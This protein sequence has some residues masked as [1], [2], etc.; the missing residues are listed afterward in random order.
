MSQLLMNLKKTT[1][2]TDKRVA[3]RCVLSKIQHLFI[4]NP[5]L[6]TVKLFLGE[7]ILSQK[8][9]SSALNFKELMTAVQFSLQTH[10]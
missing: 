8:S 5:I 4:W 9:R 1:N 6:C 7:N 10:R 2:P 3:A